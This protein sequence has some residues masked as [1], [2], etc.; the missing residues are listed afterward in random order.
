MRNSEEFRSWKLDRAI[1]LSMDPMFSN[2]S[3]AWLD[4]AVRLDYPYMFEWLGVPTIQFPAD[5]LLI[6]EAIYRSKPTLILEVGIARGGTTLFVASV[7]KIL[8]SCDKVNVIGIDI[9]ISNH[10]RSAIQESKLSDSITLIEGNSIDEETLSEVRSMIKPED[11]IL[12]ILD[13]NHTKDHVYQEMLK[14]QGFV[15]SGSFLIVM[16]TAIEYISPRLI[17]PDKQWSK[18]N[19]PLSAIQKYM[20]SEPNSFEIDSELNNRS[21]PGAC[22]GGFLRK[23]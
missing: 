3:Q 11:R 9:L 7:M 14:Y 22:R 5:L 1:D 16:D 12:V 15:S 21:F 19:S 13:S 2:L 6:Q 23:L 17:P 10:T 8:N 18:G 4:E 20:K